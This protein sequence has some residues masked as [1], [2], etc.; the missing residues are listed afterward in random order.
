MGGRD[1]IDI[2]TQGADNKMDA[3]D[4]KMLAKKLEK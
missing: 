3:K 2:R 4:I 1:Q